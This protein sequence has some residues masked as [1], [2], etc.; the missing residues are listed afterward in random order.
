[1]PESAEVSDDCRRYCIVQQ[2]G[3]DRMVRWEISRSIAQYWDKS[4][5]IQCLREDW[6]ECC[7]HGAAWHTCKVRR[8]LRNVTL[9]RSSWIYEFKIAVTFM[10]VKY[11]R[12]QSRLRRKSVLWGHNLRSLDWIYIFSSLG[13]VPRA[14]NFNWLTDWSRAWK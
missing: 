3:R 6:Q 8:D 1:M 11:I 4:R 2:V 7:C 9:P 5:Q 14:V 12:Q 10:G 13:L